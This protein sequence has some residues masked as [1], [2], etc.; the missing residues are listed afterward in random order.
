MDP[1]LNKKYNCPHC[2][3]AFK[4]KKYLKDHSTKHS[5]IKSHQCILCP[6]W[7]KYKRGLARHKKL[8]HPDF[9]I[10]H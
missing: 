3:R 10:T 4:L 2:S 1:N 9:L 7:Y 8:K 5:P 6:K